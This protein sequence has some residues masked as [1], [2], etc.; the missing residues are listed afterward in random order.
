MFL[1]VS[2]HS[3]TGFLSYLEH[4]TWNIGPGTLDLELGPGTTNWNTVDRKDLKVESE[5]IG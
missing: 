3:D 2:S 5:T 1:V 4:W